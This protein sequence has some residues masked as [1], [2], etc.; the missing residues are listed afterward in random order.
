MVKNDINNLKSIKDE[1]VQEIIS[2]VQNDGGVV[3]Y[4]YL[5]GSHCHGLNTETSD[6][7]YGMFYASKMENL[8]DLGFKYKDQYADDKNDVYCQEIKKVSHLLLKSNPTVLE[9]LFVDDE[10]VI[11]EHPVITVLKEN[12]DKFLTKECYKPFYGYA[13]SQLVK[14]SSQKKAVMK[15]VLK[16]KLPIDFAMCTYKQGSCH[17]TTWLSYR[18]LK[19]EYCGL[20]N[21]ANMDGVYSVFYDWG[22]HFLHENID[23]DTLIHWW[24][25]RENGK[26]FD[27]IRTFKNL[28]AAKDADDEEGIKIYQAMLN[29]AQKVALIEYI[30][31]TY[32]GYDAETMEDDLRKFYEEHSKKL[33]G[34]KGVCGEDSQE[35]RLSSVEKG[36]EPIAHIQYTKDKFSQ[37]CKEY[38]NQ[39]EWIKN[40]NPER[41]RQN[42]ENMEKIKERKEENG[43]YD[44]KNFA[45]MQRLLTTYLEIVRDGKYIVNR[46]DID[47]E[48]LLKIKRGELTYNEIMQNAQEKMKEAEKYTETCTLPEHADQ[49]FLNNWLLDVRMKQLRREL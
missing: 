36:A 15:K 38:K 5:R 12:R 40:R 8:L 19:P 48:Y 25:T 27:M 3:L 43:F 47:R 2:Q 14:G 11:Y 30:A 29:E 13:K 45:E 35:L 49:E 21:V 23:A 44:A 32:F 24:R 42:I 9:T 18:G 17:F 16:R 34:Y 4:L 41:F 20:V 31:D 7:D 39:Q 1:R 26:S 37:H 46:R 28:E 33:L 22:N 6:E 10:F